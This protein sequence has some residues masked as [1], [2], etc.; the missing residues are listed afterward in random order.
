MFHFELKFGQPPSPAASGA[1]NKLDFK[2][3]IPA[4][5][6]GWDVLFA[7]SLIRGLPWKIIG[8]NG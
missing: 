6:V 3:R 7:L 4:P 5:L 2:S 1:E 8:A